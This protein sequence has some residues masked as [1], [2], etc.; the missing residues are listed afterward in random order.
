M[1]ADFYAS[2]IIGCEIEDDKL[3]RKI[4]VAGCHHKNEPS[5][6]WCPDCGKPTKVAKEYYLHEEDKDF[7]KK[8]KELGLVI[9][10][11]TDRKGHVI[12]LK[13]FCSPQ[14][15]ISDTYGCYDKA[16]VTDFTSAREQTMYALDQI[17]MWDE[18]TFGLWVVGYCSY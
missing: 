15:D 2:A 8:C 17:D 16:E 18:K 7:M 6:K 5:A 14:V 9:K 4:V 11:C 12:G 10:D 1:G 3:I 13:K